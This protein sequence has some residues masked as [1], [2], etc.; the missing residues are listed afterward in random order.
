MQSFCLAECVVSDLK[1]GLYSQRQINFQSPCSPILACFIL[2][3]LCVFIEPPGAVCRHM[4]WSLGCLV[5][6]GHLV[7]RRWGGGAGATASASP[8]VTGWRELVF[9]LFP[10]TVGSHSTQARTRW[11]AFRSY[12]CASLCCTFGSC[13][14]VCCCSS[15]WSL[16]AYFLIFQTTILWI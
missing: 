9:L 6:L 13:C 16:S 15:L 11:S 5:F 7:Q 12:I 3:L 1:F 2:D 8:Y 4:R 10:S 14:V